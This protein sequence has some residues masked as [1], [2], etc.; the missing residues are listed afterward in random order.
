MKRRKKNTAP[1]ERTANPIPPL[2]PITEGAMQHVLHRKIEGEIAA[3]PVDADASESKPVET[4]LTTRAFENRSLKQK[5][6]RVPA[7][8]A[9]IGKLEARRVLS[10][11]PLLLDSPTDDEIRTILRFPSFTHS[12]AGRAL[13][14][15]ERTIRRM[16]KSHKLTQSKKKRI[17][18][19]EQFRKALS[20]THGKE[21]TGGTKPKS[22]IAHRVD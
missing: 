3:I 22:T 10:S 13:R 20:Q 8:E 2:G 12:E 16:I 21:F 9:R 19:D 14:C 6:K 17:Q 1:A 11:R 18:N 15:N 5:A 7:L 4:D